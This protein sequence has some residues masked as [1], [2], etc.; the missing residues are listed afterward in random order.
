MAGRAAG[1]ML[2]IGDATGGAGR[3]HVPK[4]IKD[5]IESNLPNV[6]FTVELTE[7]GILYKPTQAVEIP[8][9]DL[10]DW[11]KKVAQS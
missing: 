1:G 4:T 3:L 5:A 8:V 2:K 10:P 11:L 9:E 6:H 7:E